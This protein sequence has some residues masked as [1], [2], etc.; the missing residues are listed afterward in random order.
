LHEKISFIGRNEEEALERAQ[1][2]LGL[3]A[4]ALEYVVVGRRKGVFGRVFSQLTIEVFVKPERTE[5][6]SPVAEPTRP[7]KPARPERSPQR[8][9]ERSPR[10]ER[11]SRPAPR[12]EAPA[13]AALDVNGD[14]GEQAEQ[15]ALQLLKQMGFDT[16][17]KVEDRGDKVIVRLGKGTKE[18]VDDAE[19]AEAFQFILNKI[20]NRFPPR[21]K[22][23]VEVPGRGRPT[24][25]ELIERA[26]AWIKQAKDSGKDLWLDNLNPR[27]RR[28]V[29][30]EVEKDDTVES[31]SEGSGRERRMCVRVL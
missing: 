3:P 25:D 9:P 23:F 19:I 16:T 2:A 31:I 7:S 26:L 13:N 21:K 27:E 12:S 4:E 1:R 24:D 20:V 29:H 10:P 28:I 15:V 11:S 30:L 6:V 17:V 22:I 18:M 8:S 14:R 5:P